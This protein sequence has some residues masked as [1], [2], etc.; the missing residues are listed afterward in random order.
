MPGN[1]GKE[2]PRG[3]FL[4]TLCGTNC[5]L[6]AFMTNNFSSE[7]TQKNKIMFQVSNAD[8]LQ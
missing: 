3:R 4:L 5:F 8:Y 2:L 1:K 6:S 7:F